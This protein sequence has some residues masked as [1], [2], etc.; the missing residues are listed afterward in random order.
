MHGWL[1]A[2]ALRVKPLANGLAV[3]G[4]QLAVSSS[5]MA[6]R[7]SDLRAVRLDC[8]GLLEHGEVT[9]ANCFMTQTR[10]QNP[11]ANCKLPTA[12]R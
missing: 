10:A 3:N 8:I 11:T 6:A 7:G 9:G 5:L 4:W 2:I 1:I 12:N